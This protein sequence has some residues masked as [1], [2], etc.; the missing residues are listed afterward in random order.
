M[1]V[2]GTATRADNLRRIGQAAI[3]RWRVAERG[4]VG[5]ASPTGHCPGGVAAR[6]AERGRAVVDEGSTVPYRLT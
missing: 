3:P 1:A 6:D 5:G 4:A 2:I